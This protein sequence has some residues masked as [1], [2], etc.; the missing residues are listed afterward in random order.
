M[1]SGADVEDV[2]QEALV[3]AWR[4]AHSC[5]SE[6]P[7]AWVV[8]I[9]RR[10]VWRRFA[11]AKPE[12]LGEDVGEWGSADLDEAGVACRLDVR[13]EVRQMTESDRQVLYLRYVCDLTQPAIARALGIPEGTTKVRLHR[14]RTRLRAQ[15]DDTE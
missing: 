4:H 13:R 3:R 14:A 8:A 7:T 12:S 10:E 15:L 1:G 9:T 11:A 6:D 2:V 5:T